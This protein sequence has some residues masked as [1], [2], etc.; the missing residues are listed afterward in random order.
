VAPAYKPFG[1]ETGRGGDPERESQ[2][3][4]AGKLGG[5]RLGVEKDDESQ[6]RRPQ[7]QVKDLPEEH[8]TGDWVMDRRKGGAQKP[9]EVLQKNDA[10]I[11][12]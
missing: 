9:I 10:K 8:H 4:G 1:I 12:Q 5:R 3:M 2:T 7:P 11:W 6:A